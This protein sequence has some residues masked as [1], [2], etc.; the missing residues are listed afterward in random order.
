MFA[1]NWQDYVMKELKRSTIRKYK[2]L[3][4]KPYW[5]KQKTRIY[6]NTI[7]AHFGYSQGLSKR[8]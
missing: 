1:E 4:T 6:N 2:N 7:P 8:Y 5:S 3:K